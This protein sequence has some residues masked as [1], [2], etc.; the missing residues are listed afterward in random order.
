M[1]L[2][3][4]GRLGL[5]S[6]VASTAFL[7]VSVVNGATPAWAEEGTNTVNSV[8]GFFGMR[9][10]KDDT[11]IDYHAR[12]PLVVPPRLDLPQP[13]AA[14]RDPSWPKDPDVAAERRA[15]L[16]AQ[17]PVPQIAPSSGGENGQVELQQHKSALPSDGPPDECQAGS[18]PALCLST[19]WKALSS[20]VTGL[21]SDTAP[22]GPEPARKFLTEPPPGYRQATGAAKAAAEAP[23]D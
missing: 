8:L 11:S 20:I 22:T 4:V 7:L 15:A 13:K 21:H 2:G 1:T 18:G 12:P 19:P 9:F 14:A 5:C 10:D 3:M 6:A 23:K 17:R 16:Q